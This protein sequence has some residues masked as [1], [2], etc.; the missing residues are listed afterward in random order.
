MKIV[1]SKGQIESYKGW[2]SFKA[3]PVNDH[4]L[5]CFSTLRQCVKGC[6][7]MKMK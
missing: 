5:S 2:F 6:F 1:N 3:L 7:K 4:E